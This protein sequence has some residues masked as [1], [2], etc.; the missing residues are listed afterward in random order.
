MVFGDGKQTRIGIDEEKFTINGAYTYHGTTF[1]GRSI[2]GLLLN[3]R[4]YGVGT[5]CWDG[6]FTDEPFLEDS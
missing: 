4:T 3:L 5:S 2:E 1:E 6:S